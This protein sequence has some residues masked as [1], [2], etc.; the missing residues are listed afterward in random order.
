MK[1]QCNIVAILLFVVLAAACNPTSQ[2]AGTATTLP[3][4]REISAE[5]LQNLALSDYLRRI[6]GLRVESRGSDV[7]VFLRGNSS[8]NGESS[9]LFVIDRNQ[10]GTDYNIASSMVDTNDIA[11]VRLLQISEATS[12]YGMRGA[13]GAI[14]IKTKKK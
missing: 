13:N 1:K 12:M 9:P 8:F 3:N 7:N 11:S 6:P 14:E 5:N 4:A 2:I 10:V